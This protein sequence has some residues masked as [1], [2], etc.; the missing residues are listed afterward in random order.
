[1]QT[2]FISKQFLKFLIVGGTCFIT[3]I[4]VLYIGTDLLGL[5]Y[6]VS[7]LFSIATV[8]FIG[9]AL[10]RHQTF[11]TKDADALPEFTRYILVNLTSMI[12]SLCTM[13]LLV[14]T[15]GLHYIVA[16]TVIAAGM[17]TINFYAHRQWSFKT[18]PS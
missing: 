14:S 1:M 15:V 12:T 11:K 5:H 8:N 13:Y 18:K 4:L 3:N 7:M 6:L 17:T 9:W 2:V 16:S 10:N